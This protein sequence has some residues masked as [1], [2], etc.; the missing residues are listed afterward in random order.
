MTGPVLWTITIWNSN[1]ASENL[2]TMNDFNFAN[3]FSNRVM[4]CSA[5]GAS[6]CYFRK[7]VSNNVFQK[8]L[9]NFISFS[10][11]FLPTFC[12]G[13]CF[14]LAEDYGKYALRKEPVIAPFVVR[15]KTAT[16]RKC[17]SWMSLVFTVICSVNFIF[18]HHLLIMNRVLYNRSRSLFF[19]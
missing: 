10:I 18:V 12:Q 4:A 16:S 9:L 5:K 3:F 14:L 15:C 7:A 2:R 8:I 11:S 17:S 1:H 19:S 6:Y 13:G